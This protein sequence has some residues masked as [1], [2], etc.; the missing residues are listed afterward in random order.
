M[1]WNN[2]AQFTPFLDGTLDS[3]PQ[4]A[5]TMRL[6]WSI[7]HTACSDATS[8]ATAATQFDWGP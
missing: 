7:F 1:V 8:C 6:R 2:P 5:E 4:K 3:T